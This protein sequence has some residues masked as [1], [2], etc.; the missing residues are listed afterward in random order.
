M[1]GLPYQRFA[2]RPSEER[3]RI[4]ARF[5]RCG[6]EVEPIEFHLEIPID[7][8]WRSNGRVLVL[9]QPRNQTRSSDLVR[10][11]ADVAKC[12]KLAAGCTRP[13]M[14]SWRGERDGHGMSADAG[15]LGG[16]DLLQVAVLV[17]N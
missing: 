8:T 4:E 17:V 9:E 3:R 2:P 16:M 5:G 13:K 7:A 11:T 15:Q 10:T 6:A 14:S 1:A 12:A